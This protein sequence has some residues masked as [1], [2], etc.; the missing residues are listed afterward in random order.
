MPGAASASAQD[1]PYGG[2]PTQIGRGVGVHKKVGGVN[3]P[4]PE[5]V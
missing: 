2:L 5:E 3:P 4:P 1:D